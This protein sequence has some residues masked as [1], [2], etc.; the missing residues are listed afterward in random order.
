ML[1][2][3][4]TDARR[5]SA[6]AQE[7]LRR[8][9]VEAVRR[10]MTQ[11]EAARVFGVSRMAIHQWM[12]KYDAGGRRALKARKRGRPKEPRLKPHEAATIVRL[13]T[14]RC[15]DQLKMP[16]ALWTRAAV[17]DLIAARTGQRLSVWTVGR[18]LKRWGMTPQKPVRRAWER[19]ER[20][21][22]AWLEDD[23]PAIR[24]DAAAQKAEIHWGDEMGMRSDHQTG[25]TY[26]RK[27]H[28]P[29][30]RGTGQRFSCN[31]IST[32]TNRGTLRFMVFQGRFTGL[33]FIAFLQRL[34]QSAERTVFLIVDGHPVHRAT[35]VQ[36]W[37]SARAEA[38]RLFFLP[39]YS[40]ELNPDERL[41]N[42]V[43]SNAVGRRRARCR[44]ELVGN[45]RAYLRSTQRRPDIV[46]NYFQEK[47][48]RYAAE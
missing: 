22:A 34:I 43:K 23:Y 16:F 12:R 20:A 40:P 5:L 42:D 17:G 27:G 35:A 26:G 36:R 31:M 9:A 37:L 13:I 1:K 32:I 15:P 25:T 24:R 38:I 2:P 47:S 44:T 48:V 18:Y 11:S 19:D 4:G 39:A 30:V 3:G 6:E 10:G 46:R 45:V 41:N 14:D 28:T 33:V 29:V 21:V 7:A 8:R